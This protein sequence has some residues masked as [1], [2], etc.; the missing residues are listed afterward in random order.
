MTLPGPVSIQCHF[1][2]FVSED[3]GLS[4][5]W[6][7]LSKWRRH[8]GFMDIDFTPLCGHWHQ[9]N[10]IALTYAGHS[11]T[12]KKD[13]E[14]FIKGICKL[15]R[16][17]W[18]GASAHVRIQQWLI[19]KFPKT[20]APNLIFPNHGGGV[21]V[22]CEMYAEWVPEDIQHERYAARKLSISA[23]RLWY[24]PS[25]SFYTFFLDLTQYSTS[26]KISLNKKIIIL[27]NFDIIERSIWYNNVPWALLNKWFHILGLT[28]FKLPCQSADCGKLQL[29]DKL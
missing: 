12:E 17:Q 21:R 5:A 14:L 18:S 28:N 1:S 27:S 7:M 11:N 26:I 29:N 24:F 23:F 20:G 9:D 22:M 15:G 16:Y 25:S 8:D 10:Y 4:N 19:Q 13:L 2:L 6:V 3:L